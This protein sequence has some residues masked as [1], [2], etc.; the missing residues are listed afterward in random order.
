[1]TFRPSDGLCEIHT[2]PIV[3]TFQQAH[4]DDSVCYRHFFACLNI[5]EHTG[6]CTDGGLGAIPLLASFSVPTERSVNLVAYARTW[7]GSR[8]TLLASTVTAV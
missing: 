8:R 5:C 2:M 7:I 1:M 4:N 6:T 3:G